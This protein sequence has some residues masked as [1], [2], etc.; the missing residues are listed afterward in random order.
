MDMRNDQLDLESVLM[1]GAHAHAANQLPPHHKEKIEEDGMEKPFSSH[2][3]E[4][5]GE[6]T[7]REGNQEK[8]RKRDEKV[9]RKH[10]KD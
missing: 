5:E 6:G 3:G 10:P 1:K 9:H 7:L 2:E 8:K 4:E